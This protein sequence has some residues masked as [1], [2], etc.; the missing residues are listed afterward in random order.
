MRDKNSFITFYQI[1]VVYNQYSKL[2]EKQGLV[3]SYYLYGKNN[4]IISPLKENPLIIN[5]TNIYDLD[6]YQKVYRYINAPYIFQKNSL[7]ASYDSM[8][9]LFFEDFTFMP[10]TYIYPKQKGIIYKK[11]KNYQLNLDDLWLV[12]PTNKYGGHG[13]YIFDSLKNI[14]LDEF[15]ITKYIKNVNLIK[16]KKYDLRLYVLLTGLKPMRIYFYKEGLVRIASEKYSLN[17]NSIQNKFVHLTNMC[18]NFLNKN[19]IRPNSSDDENSN[20]WNILM[21]KKYLEQYNIEW[22]NIREKIKDIIIKS[23]ISV[24]KNLTDENERIKVNDQSF[25]EILG[26]DILINEKFIP[27]LSEI[28]CIPEMFLSNNLDKKIKTDL[29]YDT[30]NL[31]G[32]VPYSR[33]KEES[34]NEKFRTF[35]DFEDNINNAICELERP[36]GDYELIFPTKDNIRKYSKYFINNS[37]ENKK[38]WNHILHNS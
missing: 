35:D 12:K 13:I 23:I 19:Y 16:G 26:F 29:F 27:K 20:L 36:R 14:K 28:N 38:F 2:L 34:L 8:K 21:Y 1:D 18:V 15:I 25:Y 30:L 33:K 5:K 11:F 3:R 4:L 37:R 17:M 6:K 24:H 9:N 22:E 31:I 32:I 7:Y 10:E